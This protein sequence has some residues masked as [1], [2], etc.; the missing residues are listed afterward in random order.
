MTRQDDSGIAKARDKITSLDD[1]A[2]LCVAVRQK[3]QRVVHCHGVFDLLHMG[4]VRHFEE[5]RQHGDFLV[6]T[7][8]EDAHVNKGPGRPIFPELLR[9]EMVAAIG[10]VDA[11][12]IN[13]HPSAETAIRA[14]RPHV[15][16][17]GSDYEDAGSDIT[18][19][20]ESERGEVEA[21]GGEIAFT[22]G[23]TF[24]SSSL[25]NRYFDVY[26]PELRC[27]LETAREK[28][29]LHQING[30]MERVQGFRVLLVGDAI[31]DEYRYVQPLGKSPKE[32]MIATIYKDSEV[33]AGGVIAAA[34]HVASFCSQVDVITMIGGASSQD[35]EVI[36][37]SLL[38]NVR[39]HL[40]TRPNVPTTRK[41][42]FVDL[43][44]MRKLFEVYEM[45]DSYMGRPLE[46]E[47][48]ALIADLAPR[49]DLTVV[50]DFGHG[51][52]TAEC[53]QAI[54]KH[55]RFFALNAQSNS[56]NLGFNLVTKYPKADYV[57]IDTP[58]LRLSM[59]DKYS[60]I[61]LL[62]SEH[63][64]KV[65]ACTCAIITQGVHGCMTWQPEH[66][67]HQVPAFTKTVVDT[68][69]AGDAFFAVTAP[70]V[71]AGG[72]MSVVGFV[73]NAVGAIK[74]GIVGHRRS[75]EKEKVLKFVTA[76]LK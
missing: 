38:P 14:I 26:D 6:V 76:L 41:T 46:E 49:C 37:K 44:Y 8:T 64:H 45:D 60:D 69:G 36:R 33:F 50:T 66:G 4:H 7:L 39:L 24:S 1:A 47:L 48:L 3:G 27:Y 25:I 15:Y 32:N 17:K 30:L 51:L 5:A 75:V 34:N 11:V 54:T 9:A 58:E 71:A 67:C 16:V 70:L 28:D 13:R 42:R 68:V 62:V 21:C 23:I 61:G 12:A 52:L 74:V 18:G 29:I 73:G 65:V 2:A 43:G 55:A 72:D 40:V 31:I 35:E 63:F 10:Y 57:C 56:A 22:K 20:I 19:K 59:G 53:R